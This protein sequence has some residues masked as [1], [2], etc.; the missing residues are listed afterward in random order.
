MYTL[1][2]VDKRT[3]DAM[4]EYRFLFRPFELA[5]QVA[6]CHWNADGRTAEDAIPELPM[7]LRGKKEYRAIIINSDAL[8]SDERIP[9]PDD[10]NP[11]DYTSVDLERGAHE[12]PIPLIRLTH[13]LAGY[14]PLPKRQFKAMIEYYD[15]E[16]RCMMHVAP[17][18]YNA[19]RHESVDDEDGNVEDLGK[20][21]YIEIEPD[22]A[23]IEKHRELY[24][25]Y[26]SSEA[27][28][29]EILLMSLRKRRAEDEKEETL[30]AWQVPIE[31]LSSSFWEKNRYPSC[32]R[33]LYANVDLSDAM[34]AE[35]D[36]TSFWFSAVLLS[37][38]RIPTAY[39]Q[40]YRLYTIGVGVDTGVFER[41]LCEHIALL[42]KAKEYVAEAMNELPK[43]SLDKNAVI[44]EP[45]PIPV[46][47]EQDDARNVMSK[48]DATH[49]ANPKDALVKDEEKERDAINDGVRDPRRAIDRAA[50]SMREQVR[51][52]YGKAYELDEV[53]YE[54]L[55]RDIEEREKSVLK[56]RPKN[57]HDEKKIKEMAEQT[58]KDYD[59]NRGELLGSG[60]K[61]KVFIAVAC[62]VVLGFAPCLRDIIAGYRVAD[63]VW[64][65]ASLMTLAVV[66]ITL[67]GGYWGLNIHEAKE[68]DLI[69]NIAENAKESKSANEK[70]Q[71]EYTDFFSEAC[72]LMYANS[73]LNGA[74]I[75]EDSASQWRRKLYE[76]A[77]AI[78]FA[79]SRDER[80]LLAY[81]K[82]VNTD[83]IVA[84][85]EDFDVNVEP[86]A[87][88]L[89]QLKPDI[90]GDKIEINRSG[91]TLDAPYRFIGSVEIER[92]EIFDE[93]EGVCG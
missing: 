34:K 76:H 74:K 87:N 39:M 17:E 43:A 38:N 71:K 40:A 19:L 13:I 82:R 78:E 91:E 21:I 35:R 79:R 4:A 64:L 14:E 2:F 63:L 12:S 57:Y 55:I 73:V 27:R 53:Q 30:G 72:T 18:V 67:I 20:P 24:E 22:A 88:H 58:K 90:D 6:F 65:W 92:V 33:F 61:M 50:R 26:L 42:D 11:F 45:I 8:C 9:R 52:F 31:A 70:T 85:L 37:T 51:L 86:A 28:P 69:K 54:Q 68:K 23:E 3:A 7:L 60:T 56:M 83:D 44:V 10:K 48:C 36:L 49:G 1:I 46:I 16:K 89:Y 81:D 47:I 62:V 66:I 25:R 41:Q 77:K 93:F 15:E 29:S 80:W 75:C 5:G 32:C 84:I 59:R